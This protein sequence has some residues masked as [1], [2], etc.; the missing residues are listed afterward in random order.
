MKSPFSNMQ[1][2]FDIFFDEQATITT[3]D[4]K[5]TSFNV[6]V[7]T[8]GTADTFTDDMMESDRTDM[9]FVFK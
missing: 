8:D 2:A 9:T 3:T 7:F 6:C 1:G 4:G 5:R